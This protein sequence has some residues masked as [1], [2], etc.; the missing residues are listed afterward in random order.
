[1]CGE[2]GSTPL[3]MNRSDWDFHLQKTLIGQLQQET[4]MYSTLLRSVLHHFWSK[5]S[6]SLH[7]RALRSLVPTVELACTTKLCSAASPGITVWRTSIAVLLNPVVYSEKTPLLLLRL[8]GQYHE[9]Q[10]PAVGNHC[11]SN[12]ATQCTMCMKECP[13]SFNHTSITPWLYT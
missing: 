3:P 10:N 1:M 11:Y 6:P 5:P 8:L 7:P 9:H 12:I 2:G 13:R 4:T